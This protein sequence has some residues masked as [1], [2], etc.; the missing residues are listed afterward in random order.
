MMRAMHI[1]KIYYRVDEKKTPFLQGV[2]EYACLAVAHRDGL[3]LCLALL[4]RCDFSFLVHGDHTIAQAEN[5][6][7]RTFHAAFLIGI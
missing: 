7:S 1:G 2:F 5:K 4:F 6:K 3:S